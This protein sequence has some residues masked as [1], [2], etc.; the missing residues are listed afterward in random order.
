ML[1]KNG[2]HFVSASMCKNM[3]S[4]YIYGVLPFCLSLNVLKYEVSI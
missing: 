3:K 1:S 2:S 4:A